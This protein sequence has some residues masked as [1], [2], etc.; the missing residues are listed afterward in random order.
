LTLRFLV[1]GASGLIGRETVRQL[2]GQG[3][4]VVCFDLAEQF[5]R[6]RSF[7]ESLKKTGKVAFFSGTM[8]DRMSV[9]EAMNG[10]DVVIHLGA[11]LGVR[12]TEEHKLRCIQVNVNGTE[13]V[14]NVAA[15]CGVKHFIFASSSEVYGEPDSCPINEQADTKGKTLY[16]VTKLAGEGLVDG[17]HQ[18]FPSM[19]YTI[20]RLFNTY[21]EGQVSQFVISK[22]VQAVLKG[23]APTVYGAGK[24]KRSYAHVIDTVRGILLSALNPVTYSRIYNIGNSHEVVTLTELAWQVIKVLQPNT[25]IKPNVLNTYESSDRSQGREIFDRW[26]DTSLAKHDFGYSPEITLEDGIQRVA[27]AGLAH[28]DWPTAFETAEKLND[29]MK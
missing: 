16:G 27:K 26:C 3:H 6:H 8:L 23:E 15:L 14:L 25:D 19:N 2:L 9:H 17:Y 21:G 18:L 22:F 1:T 7:F 28:S 4:E 5:M 24:Q 11:M 13:I 12:R 29:M 10:C 20:V